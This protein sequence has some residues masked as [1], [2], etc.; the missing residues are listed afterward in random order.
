MKR[1]K[2]F[3][4]TIMFSLLLCICCLF[5]GCAKVEG[6]YKFNK[7]SYTQ[8]GVKIELEAGEEFMGMMTLSEDFATLTLDADGTATMIISAEEE[9]TLNGTWKKIDNSSIELT[10]EGEAQTCAYEDG[11]ITVETE[12]V[13]LILQK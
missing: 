7:L 5:C 4:C 2:R 12:G 6:T 8:G 3:F 9:Q 10:F 13:T 1:T 11:T